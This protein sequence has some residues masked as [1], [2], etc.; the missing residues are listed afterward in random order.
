MIFETSVAESSQNMSEEPSGSKDAL[1]NQ[2]MLEPHRQRDEESDHSP[3]GEHYF[4][5]HK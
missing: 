1:C 2:L 3:A 5:Y 4:E